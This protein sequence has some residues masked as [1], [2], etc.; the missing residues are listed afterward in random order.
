VTP[1]FANTYFVKPE[2]S[3]PCFG[4]FPPQ[5]YFTPTYE[6]AVRN[7]RVAAAVGGGDSGMRRLDELDPPVVVV[8]V[9]EGML[10]MTVARTDWGDTPSVAGEQ[11]VRESI[12]PAAI[13]PARERFGVIMPIGKAEPAPLAQATTSGCRASR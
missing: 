1:Y 7:T 5:T 2:Q 4:V 3:N 8:V 11:P 10:A 9:E 6:S 12:V 13:A